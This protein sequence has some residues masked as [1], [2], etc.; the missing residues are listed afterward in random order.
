L[1]AIGG[2]QLDRHRGGLDPTPWNRA[3]CE[4]NAAAG[5]PHHP[6]SAWE[7]IRLDAGDAEPDG[8]HVLRHTAATW[9]VEKGYDLSAIAP[10][11]G[12]SVA[13][14]TRAIGA[15]RRTSKEASPE[16][17]PRNAQ[18][19]RERRVNQAASGDAGMQRLLVIDDDSRL[20]NMLRD[21]L[22]EAGFRV[23]SVAGGG[24]GLALLA[25]ESYDAV[26]L[27]LMLPDMDGLEVCRQI[28]RRDP[29]LPIL[30]LT[31][32][33][34]ATDRIV[35]LELG[36]DDY[37]P[38]P[39]EPRELLARLRAILRRS[40]AA[41]TGEVLRFGRLEID[42][43]AR[44]VR[45]DGQCRPLTGHQFGLLLI[46]AEHAGRVMTREALMDILKAEPR[47]AF[48]RSID[49]HISRIRAAI[50]DDAKRPRRILTVRGTGYV[51]AKAQD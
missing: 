37:L 19:T 30:M 34:D 11:L 40:R 10:Y 18:E 22:G 49:V 23:A 15:G 3:S 13:T 32:R 17:R 48:D 43:G 1:G 26:V 7:H 51:F 28:R 27:D 33:G 41:D 47:E 38:K 16:L 29:A 8:P 21:Y 31:A 20:A 2:F 42:R 45:L 6:Y 9:Y 35:G 39:F 5:V 12:T 50:E 24:A 46:L 25:R 36:A 14:L 44:E 4:Q